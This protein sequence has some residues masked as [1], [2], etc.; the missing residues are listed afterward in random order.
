[1]LAYAVRVQ[2]GARGFLP[3]GVYT[4]FSICQ[5]NFSEMLNKESGAAKLA[6]PA[7]DN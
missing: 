7:S 2:M 1:M 4:M 6:S 5:A 3:R